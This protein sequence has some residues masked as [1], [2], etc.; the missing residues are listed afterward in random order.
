MSIFEY[1]VVADWESRLQSLEGLAEQERWTF[2]S[3]P[4]QS[5]A[6]ILEAYVRHT[7]MRVREQKKIT[8][9]SDLSC[10]NT[11]LLTPSQEEIFG[12]F[13]VSDRYDD[14]RP[15][16]KTNKKWFLTTW[17]RSG[18]RILTDFPELPGLATYWEDPSDLILNPR[19]RVQP[20]LD[21]IIRE[22]LS[23]F[24]VELGG[25]LGTDGVPQEEATVPDIEAEDSASAGMLHG[26]ADGQAEIPLA[27]RNALEGAIKHSVRL[28]KR[29]YR[30]AVPQY[31]RARDRGR[32]QLLLPL[33]LR[34]SDSADLAL[35]LE[36]HGEWYRAA[37]VLYPDWAYL[38]ARLLSRPNSEWLG[39][40]RTD[41]VP[42]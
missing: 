42:I 4:S 19:L 17:A 21:H 32:I 13:R 1:A 41:V 24:P 18:A 33:Y 15:E 40:F 30:V 22:N 11:G 7:F 2:R 27:T 26:D 16:S 5:P 37:T 39:G 10:F 35:T 6:P 9:A 29:S 38:N 31:Y 28:A 8:E 25:S 34:D 3:V 14:T 36:R 20:N 23:R 12:V